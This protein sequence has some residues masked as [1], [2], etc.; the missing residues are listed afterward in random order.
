M[1]KMWQQK[2]DIKEFT[3]GNNINEFLNNLDLKMDIR[4]YCIFRPGRNVYNSLPG[5][6]I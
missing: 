1:F 6:V 2:G 5:L 4:L 3:K